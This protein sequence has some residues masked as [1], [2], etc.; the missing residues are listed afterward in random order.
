MNIATQ[1]GFLISAMVQPSNIVFAI[2][3]TVIT[4]VGIILAINNRADNCKRFMPSL[5]VSIGIFGTFWGI[6]IGLSGF[7]TSNISQSIPVMLDGMKTAFITSILGMFASITLKTFYA[8]LEDK[9]NDASSDPLK[10]LQN[11]E[12]GVNDTVDNVEDINHLIDKC[13]KSD[14]EYSL[15]SQV[16]LIRLEMVDSRNE[17]KQAFNEFASK[18]SKMASESLVDELK[19]VVDK[20]NVMLSDLVSQSF[21]DLKDSTER[22]NTWQAS[23]KDELSQNHANLIETLN[24]LSSLNDTYSQFLIKIQQLTYEMDTISKSLHEIAIDGND[25]A[26]QSKILAEQ[27]ELLEASIQAIKEAGEKASNLVPVLNSKLSEIFEDI[28]NF[29]I[30][31]NE[32]VKNVTTQINESSEE[33]TRISHEQISSIEK[34]LE[35][36]LT[37]S[38]DS[39][40]GAM[41]ALSSKFTSDYTPLTDKLRDL[42]NMAQRINNVSH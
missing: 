6:F 23:Y 29:N 22:L 19:K 30:K 16:K 13:F 21:K 33:I 3:I 14:E 40:A 9:N 34:S 20:F 32:F 38:L 37:K 11:I 4:A 26:K 35:T 15:V 39:F 8:I 28:H 5:A 24:Q 18:F 27:N 12:L 31:I 7:D 42:I 36:E 1:I 41:V 10:C 25:I 2:A 17:L